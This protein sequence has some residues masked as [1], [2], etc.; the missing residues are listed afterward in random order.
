[1]TGG[2]IQL[3]AYGVQDM[4]LTQDPQITFFKIVYR[5]HTN[6]SIEEVPQTFTHTPDFGKRVSC[7]VSR[8]GDLVG[9]IVLVVTLPEIPQLYNTNG[10]IDSLTKFAWIRK[11]GYGLIKEIEVEIGGQSIDKHYG[12][13]L[14]IWAD[15]LG[16]KNNDVNRAIGNV[17][18][19]YTYSATKPEYKIFIPLQF[20]FCRAS[21]LAL[22]IL[23]LQYNDVKINLELSD[24]DK[25][26][27]VTPTHYIQMENDLVNFTIDEYISQTIDTYFAA[28][29]FTYFDPVLKRLYYRRI[30]KN[31]LLPLNNVNYSTYTTTQQQE[32]QDTYSIIGYTSNYTAC[33]IINTSSTSVYSV[34]YTHNTYDN[35]KIKECFLLVNYIFLDEDERLKF[36]KS[37]HEYVIEQLIY[38]GE[39]SLDG[40]NRNVRIGL[41]QPCK[42]M[43]WTTH[44]NYLLETYNNDIFNYTDSYIYDSD[45]KQI[46][47]NIAHY[48]TILLNGHERMGK[49]D[50][51]YYNSIH[52]WQYFKYNPDQGIN[53]YSFGVIPDQVQPSGQCNMSK[54]DN[55][56]LNLELS[57]QV[58]ISNPV[59]F[60]C[61]GLVSNVFRV[62]SGLGGLVFTN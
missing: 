3:V 52:P 6:F 23:C 11:I 26:Y 17:H 41:I 2:L 53:I 16:P 60:K 33:P 43:A 27:T 40:V 9:N 4:F 5:R 44:F 29:Q 51:M 50:S 20:W 35:L 42:L 34:A 15:L 47:S 31:L 12:E 39:Q 62:I 58:S 21:G 18:E 19:V 7:I 49:Q 22:P 30:T 14:N 45:N 8:S 36:Y 10:S 25:C 48:E 13:W 24:A 46:G 38:T 57:N 1:M 59:K 32:L 37:N 61:Y 56:Q 28:G 54:I 55:I